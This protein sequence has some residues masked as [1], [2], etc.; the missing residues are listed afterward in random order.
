MS[1]DLTVSMD[2]AGIVVEIEHVPNFPAVTVSHEPMRFLESATLSPDEAREHA[3]EVLRLADLFE[4]KAFD[5][6]DLAHDLAGDR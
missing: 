6:P 5:D 3:Y 1:N 2:R 4:A